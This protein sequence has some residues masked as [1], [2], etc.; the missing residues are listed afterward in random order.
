MYANCPIVWE[1]QIQT[2]IALSTTESKYIELYQ[3]MRGVLP[4]ASLMREILFFLELEDAV[5]KVKSSL[6]EKTIIVHEDNQGTI[7]LAV[8]PQMR[9]H[10]KHITI[11]YHNFQSFVFNG[12]VKFQ[13]VDTS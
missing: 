10:T 8:A 4:F 9:P 7:A 6:F 13:D 5:P 11:K 1:S 12:I 3:V 2:D